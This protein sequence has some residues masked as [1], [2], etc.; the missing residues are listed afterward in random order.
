MNQCLVV[1]PNTNGFQHIIFNL[2]FILI[3]KL[4]FIHKYNKI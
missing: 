4:F 3:I 2:K 1:K